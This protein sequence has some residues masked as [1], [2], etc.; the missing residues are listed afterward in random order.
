MRFGVKLAPARVGK[1]KVKTCAPVPWE[2][3]TSRGS[4]VSSKHGAELTVRDVGK[5]SAGS[6]NG[7]IHLFDA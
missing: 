1:L 5:E 7:M 3:D 2:Q 6:A 4:T